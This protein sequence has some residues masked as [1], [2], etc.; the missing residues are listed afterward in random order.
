MRNYTQHI[1]VAAIM[2]DLA[3]LSATSAQAATVVQTEH[4]GTTEQITAGNGSFA[5]P[6]ASITKTLDPFN[7]ALG[8]LDSVTINWSFGVA[9]SGIAVEGASVNMGMGPSGWIDSISF[10]T[11]GNTSVAL[12]PSP[13]VFSAATTTNYF[14]PMYFTAA[15]AG[16]TC[17]PAFWPIVSG[18]STFQARLQ[19]GF[20]GTPGGYATYYSLTSGTITTSIDLVATYTYSAIPTPGAAALIGLAGAFMSRRRRN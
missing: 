9:I 18:A 14:S 13:G 1:A 8:T 17:N 7:T 6:S 5:Y 10:G 15:N 16:F 4:W 3:C 19:D 12:T 2:F 11:V 20:N